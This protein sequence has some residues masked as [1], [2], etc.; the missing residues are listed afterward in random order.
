MEQNS[1]TQLIG[2]PAELTFTL[3]IT[4]VA[5]GKVET[6]DM[7]GYTIPTEEQQITGE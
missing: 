7:V 3:Q 6:Y 1:L 2:Q 5:T 4:R